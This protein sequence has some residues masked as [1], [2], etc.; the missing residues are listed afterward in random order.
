MAGTV[1]VF[2]TIAVNGQETN[3]AIFVGQNN[4]SNW[5]THNKNQLVTGFIFG[6]FNT[7]PSNISFYFDNDI[8]DTMIIDPD[9]QPVGP[10]AQF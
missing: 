10:S 6:A 5:Q 1:F 4:A 7:L 8:I 3:G 2:N 9:V